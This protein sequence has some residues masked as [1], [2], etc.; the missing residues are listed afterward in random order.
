MAHT[1]QDTFVVVGRAVPRSAARKAAFARTLAIVLPATLVLALLAKHLDADVAR[2]AAIAELYKISD[3]EAAR[4][5]P[6]LQQNQY[7]ASSVCSD[8]ERAA[9]FRVGVRLAGSS[10][11]EWLIKSGWGEAADC[12]DWKGVGCSE[13]GHG[14][15]SLTLAHQN[16]RGTLS[17]ELGLLHGL[18]TLDVNENGLLSGTLPADLFTGSRRL[19]SIYAFGGAV[20]GTLPSALARATLLEELELS[21][22]RLSGTIP[23]DLG[24][25]RSLRYIFLESNRISGN[26]PSQLAELRKLKELE[27]SH[28]RLSGSVPARVAGLASRLQHLD[29]SDNAPSLQGTPAMRPKQGC[30]GG[31]EKYLRG[32][33]ATGS[34]T[35]AGGSSAEG[36]TPVTY[37]QGG[38]P[39]PVRRA[40]EPPRP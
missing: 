27:V 19:K 40:G 28:N 15:E 23:A 5:A 29:L 25:A 18:T 17:S 6:T 31:S 13:A 10:N 1:Q 16:L 21:N 9:L 30:S 26:L 36:V 12:C 8:I 11:A 20:S 34:S 24:A 4:P 39:R 14:V 35:R 33:A 7:F 3:V 2:R 22:S 38:A 37:A 32:A